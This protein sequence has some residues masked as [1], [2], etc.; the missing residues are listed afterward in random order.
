MKKLLICIPLVLLALISVSP[1]F[2]LLTGT[3][4]GTGELKNALGPVAG[5]AQG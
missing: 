3:F 5:G 1:V 2:I 4:T